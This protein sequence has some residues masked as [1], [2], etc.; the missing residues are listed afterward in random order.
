MWER[1]W[2]SERAHQFCNSFKYDKRLVGGRRRGVISKDL[3]S[4][5]QTRQ[6][7]Y[8][9][10]NNDIQFPFCFSY[11]FLLLGPVYNTGDFCC[12]LSPFDW[13]NLNGL[14]YECIRPSVQSY[15]MVL[16]GFSLTKC[17]C[18]KRWTILSVSAVHRHFYISICI[19][20]LP[21]QHT[22]FI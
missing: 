22:T 3:K 18:S 12:D 17:Q 2:G 14:T 10:C 21:T 7:F 6:T 11:L 19:S 1:G 16:Y 13:C 5:H 9:S 15:V 8:K 20:T 4:S